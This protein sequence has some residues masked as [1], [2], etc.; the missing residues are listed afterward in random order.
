VGGVEFGSIAAGYAL[1]I[2]G[3]NGQVIPVTSN[4]VNAS[5]S[6]PGAGWVAVAARKSGTGY[7]LVWKHAVAGAYASWILNAEGART[8][9][10]GLTRAQAETIE[11]LVNLD[12][13]GDGKVGS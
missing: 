13:T 3:A 2:G 4:G 11:S 7:Q 5:A 1:R 8:E 10:R 12:I 6:N 9:S